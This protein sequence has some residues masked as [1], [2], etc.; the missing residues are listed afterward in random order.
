MSSCATE[1][2]HSSHSRV[3]ETAGTRP[4]R[5]RRLCHSSHSRVSET[6][7]PE[8]KTSPPLCHSSHSRVSETDLDVAR[9]TAGFAIVHIPA[10]ARLKACRGGRLNGFAIVHIPASARRTT[11]CYPARPTL[12]HSSHSRVSE[13]YRHLLLHNLVVCHSSHSRVSET[14]VR[15][16]EASERLC[17]SSHSRV[18]ET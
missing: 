15:Q 11:K 1:L 4:T 8:P 18:S 10:S 14:R 6:V 12:C 7:S 2:C 16:R 3:S 9:A 13:T 5:P 17:H